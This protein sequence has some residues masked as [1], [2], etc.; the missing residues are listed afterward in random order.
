M[1]DGSKFRPCLEADRKVFMAVPGIRDSVR[2]VLKF[3]TDVEIVAEAVAGQSDGSLRYLVRA[4]ELIEDNVDNREGY[5]WI[6]DNQI[7]RAQAV[8]LPT[9]D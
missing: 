5:W 8:V 2:T 4:G 1:A 3:A 9:L 6:K 7:L